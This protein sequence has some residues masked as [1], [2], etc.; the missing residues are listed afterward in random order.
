MRRRPS[1]S[2]FTVSPLPFDNPVVETVRLAPGEWRTG[3]RTLGVVAMTGANVRFGVLGAARIAP[4]ALIRPA[5]ANPEAT[6]EVVAA[7]DPGRADAYA[8]RHRIPR[9]ADSYEAV[10]EDP[11]IDAVYIPLPNSLHAELDPG[12]PRRPGSTCCARSPSPPTP[13][14][15]RPWPPRRIGGRR[16]PG[17]A[18]GLP[19]S[20]PPSGPSHARDRRR[21]ASSAGCATSRPGC[22]LRSPT[23]RTSGTSSTWPAE[24]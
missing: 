20:L 12:R 3:A 14:R 16:R 9:V 15:R 17:G 13:T 6:V 1:E 24:P 18:R 7:R 19:L 4:A 8:R 10:V 2:Y 11:D 5:R 21:A 23:S 22:A